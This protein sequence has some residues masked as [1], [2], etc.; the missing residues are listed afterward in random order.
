MSDTQSPGD[1]T[2]S[3]YE[4]VSGPADAERDERPLMMVER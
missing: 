3:L 1:I 4:N 2:R